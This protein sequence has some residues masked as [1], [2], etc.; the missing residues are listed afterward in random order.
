M[1]EDLEFVEIQGA[2]EEATFSRSEMDQMLDLSEAGITEIVALQKQAISDAESA[3]PADLEG[4]I[5]AFK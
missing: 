2:G 3:Q 1:T 5:N 4:L